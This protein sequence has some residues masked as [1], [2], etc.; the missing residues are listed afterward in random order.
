MANRMTRR[1]IRSNRRPNRSWAGFLPA[2]TTS[3]SAASKVLLG[4][5]GVVSSGIDETILRTVGGIMVVT[6]TTAA[7][8]I[9]VGAFGMV[10]ITDVALAAGVASIP[11]PVTNID[12]DWFIY[13][14]FAQKSLFLDATGASYPGSVW[15]PF[16][17]KA[18]RILEGSGGAVAMVVENISATFAFDVLVS[19]RILAQVRGTN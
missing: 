12:D 6:D 5:F 15:Y 7:S 2:T 9:Q 13:Q 11:S 18:K 19:L 10:P 4:S 16:D 8:E 1:L 3:V 14:S 17:S